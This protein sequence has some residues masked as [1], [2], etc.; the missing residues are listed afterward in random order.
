LK[1]QKRFAFDTETDQLGAM[2]SD[3]VG[4]SFSWQPRTGYYVPVR[5]PAGCRIVDCER[6]FEQLKPIFENEQIEKVGH[7]LKYDIQVMRQS[8]VKV[9]GVVLD[10]MI[11]A[12]IIDAG[13]LRYGINELALE[14]F[15]FRKITTDELIG[16]GRKQIAMNEVSLDRIAIYASED[17]DIAFRL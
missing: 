13:K 11:A 15:N 2:Q 14:L 5:G 3:L 9:R 10:T 6:V 12:F 1:K 8:G 4:M 16:K 17:A 7:N